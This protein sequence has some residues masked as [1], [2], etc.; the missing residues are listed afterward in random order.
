MAVSERRVVKGLCVASACFSAGAGH[1]SIL[2]EVLFRI[3]L[4][5]GSPLSAIMVNLA[6]N[7][8]SPMQAPRGLQPQDLVI[9]G[10][11]AIGQPVTAVSEPTGLVISS[12]LAGS[13][14]SGLEAGIY[15]V[16]SQLYQL[17]PGGQLSLYDQSRDG[18]QLAMAQALLMSRV[19]GSITTVISGILLPELAPARL[20]S[21]YDARGEADL[22]NVAR[23]N[24]TV[25]GAVN[26]GEILTN[27][28]A[29]WQTSAL[30]PRIGLQLAEV[31][32]GANARVAE[33]VTGT[34]DASSLT[35]A[36]MGGS[37]QNPALVLNQATNGTAIVG[38][39]HTLVQSQSASVG[40]IMTTV[41]GALNAGSVN[42][43]PRP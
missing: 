40:E 29:E 19:D 20:A 18:E 13:L 24:S 27:V 7:I 26:T 23:I 9:V 32:V 16:G 42:S 6:E 12:A 15:P 30:I 17:P 1:A 3:D 39:I 35:L 36:A 8:A 28:S 14:S 25:L 37:A 33:S 31:S 10:Y 43:E 21:V 4:M 11:D 5:G 38:R 34:A 2:E 22:L 41:I